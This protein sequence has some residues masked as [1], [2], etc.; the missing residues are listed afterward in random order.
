A[1]IFVKF[2]EKDFPTGSTFNVA[3]K[4][5]VKMLDLVDFIS[6]ELRNKP[7]PKSR[8]ISL[9]Y[10]EIGEKIAEFLKNEKWSARFQLLSKSWYYETLDINK[11]FLLKSPETIPQ[12]RKV[13][14]W[15][16]KK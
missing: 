13:I 2:A 3:D 14:D 6:L 9:K 5:P 16:K 1:E 15:Y 4:E 8:V 7:Y 12:F 10:F 11:E